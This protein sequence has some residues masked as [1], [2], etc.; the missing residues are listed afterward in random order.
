MLP[1]WRE[2]Y[3]RLLW[4]AHQ[5]RTPGTTQTL[6]QAVFER[7]DPPPS[8]G[9]MGRALQAARQLGRQRR[10]GWWHWD[11]PGQATP[12]HLVQA[13]EGELRHRVRKSQRYL[14][15]WELEWRRPGTFGGLC[16]A[17]HR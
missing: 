5:A 1:L 16:G 9:P 14:T 12:L 11:V 6:V 3:Q 7:R 4:L 2:Q 10:E 17:M 13:D 15:F 8:T